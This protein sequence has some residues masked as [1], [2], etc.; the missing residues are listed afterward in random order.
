MSPMLSLLICG[1][2][3]AGCIT[4]TIKSVHNGDALPVPFV[5]GCV[6]VLAVVA[7]LYFAGMV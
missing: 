6:S 1:V 4:C 5:W 2:I 7:M 3:F